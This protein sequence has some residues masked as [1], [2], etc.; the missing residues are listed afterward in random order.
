[1]KKLN[2]FE[3]KCFLVA[4][5][6]IL[7]T[8]AVFAEDISINNHKLMPIGDVFDYYNEAAFDD[9]TEITAAWTSNNGTI[10]IKL[11]ERTPN[12]SSGNRSCGLGNHNYEVLSS[13]VTP[14]HYLPHPNHCTFRTTV[15]W[16]CRNCPTTG[17]ETT[18]SIRWCN[19][20]EPY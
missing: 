16:R 11:V 17:E 3:F 1:M 13:I 14:S 10:G 9:F 20:N 4:F 7:C 5:M 18:T 19:G 8:T 2:F 6:M 12:S 15:R